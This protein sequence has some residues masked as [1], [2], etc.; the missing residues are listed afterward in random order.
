M[1]RISTMIFVVALGLLVWHQHLDPGGT[2]FTDVPND[3][4]LSEGWPW[5]VGA[6]G[7][8]LLPIGALLR[9]LENEFRREQKRRRDEQRTTAARRERNADQI[10][11]R[12]SAETGIPQYRR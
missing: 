3:P 11:I 10:R 2:V 6:L 8:V 12:W 7:L 9:S 5:A 1:K 4:T